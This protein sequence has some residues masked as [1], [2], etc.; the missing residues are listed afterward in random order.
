MVS[1]LVVSTKFV[2]MRILKALRQ[3]VEG[4]VWFILDFICAEFTKAFPFKNQQDFF[5]L[6]SSDYFIHF[7][8]L[9]M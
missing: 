6:R 8:N 3:C 9:S 4:F 7:L 1:V 5:F 2:R